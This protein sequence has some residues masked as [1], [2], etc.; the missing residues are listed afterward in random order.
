M[1]TRS[2]PNQV[3]T[4]LLQIKDKSCCKESHGRKKFLR[5]ILAD[6]NNARGEVEDEEDARTIPQSVCPS[7]WVPFDLF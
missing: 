7:A 6:D 5:P 1:C 2:G 3:Q 4:L